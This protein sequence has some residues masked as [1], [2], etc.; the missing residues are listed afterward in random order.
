MP[1]AFSILIFSF[2]CPNW[3]LVGAIGVGL[4]YRIGIRPFYGHHLGSG[5]RNALKRFPK[6]IRLVYWVISGWSET[7]LILDGGG[8]ANYF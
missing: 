6:Y 3:A 8:G 4:P 2:K 5:Q 7:K 1:Y